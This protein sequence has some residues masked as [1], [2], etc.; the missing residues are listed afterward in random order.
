MI[1]AKYT[2]KSVFEEGKVYKS[3]REFETIDEMEQFLAY[4]RAYIQKIQFVGS[5]KVEKDY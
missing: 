3:E 2:I 1:T 5:I 4:N